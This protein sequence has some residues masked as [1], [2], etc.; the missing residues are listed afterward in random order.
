MHCR[1]LAWGVNVISWELIWDVG[2]VLG[3][4]GL[5]GFLGVMVLQFSFAIKSFFEC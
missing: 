1:S 5:S 3:N 4:L 2:I